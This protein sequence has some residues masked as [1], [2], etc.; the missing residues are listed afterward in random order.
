MSIEKLNCTDSR[1]ES[2][3]KLN[4]FADSIETKLDKTGTAAKATADGNG[5]NIVSTYRKISDSYTKTEVDNKIANS[6]GTGDGKS[7]TKTS[8]NKLQAVGVLDAGNTSTALKY[9]TGTRSQYDAIATK[10]NNT[11][12]NITDDSDVTLTLLE[13]LY[14]VGAIYIG[15]MATCPLQVL[16]VGNWVLKASDRVLQGAGANSVGSTVEAGLPN[17]TGWFDI[18]NTTQY[19]GILYKS[20]GTGGNSGNTGGGTNR[21]QLDASGCNPIYGNSETVQPPAYIVN[22]WERIS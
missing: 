9:W 12:Y 11:I 10:D 4:K 2:L 13:T 15:T 3:K 17:I 14:P 8:D 5:N 22:I 18:V 21:L 6:T 1:V 16:G 7:I 20:I 19:D